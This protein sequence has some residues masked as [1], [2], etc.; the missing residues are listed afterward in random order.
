MMFENR[1]ILITGGT[2]SWG[3]ELTKKLLEYSPKEI[4]IFSR[5]EFAQ[6]NMKREFSDHPNLRYI[7]GDVRDYH[8]L[9]EACQDVDILFH[10]AALKHVP[11]CESQPLE[12]LK[13]NVDGTE[14]VI[15]ASILQRVKKVIDVSTDKA[16]DPINFYGMTKAVGEKLMVWANDLSQETRFVCIR[17]GNVLGTNGSVVPYFKKLIQKGENITLTSQEMTRYFLTVSQAIGLLLK[18]AEV[19]I[20]GEIFVM[21]MNS[22]RI[23]DLAQVMINSLAATNLKIEEIGVRPGEKIHEVLV[24]A[25]ESP[26]TFKYNE[27][28][29]VIL[30]MN[31]T[32]ELNSNYN[33][34]PKV[35]FR[36]YDSND[37][38]MSQNEIEELLRQGGFI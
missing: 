13:T 16:V 35:T 27:N 4:R 12:A 2:G 17:G 14:N 5:N 31:P 24:S 21:R 32:P 29:Y 26:N 20:G 36:K 19:A 37:K 1:I 18:A 15:R 11:I 8:S 38:L 30:P 6:V 28:Y 3:Y 34:L 10:L 23:V 25:H 33:H 22:C 7:I 9:F